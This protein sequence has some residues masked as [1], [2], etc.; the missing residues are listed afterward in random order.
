MNKIKIT[1]KELKE[2]NTI[3]SVGY[4]AMQSLLSYYYPI[5]YNSGIY[6]WNYDVYNIDGI[7]ICTGYRPIASQNIVPNYEMIRH[8]EKKAQNKTQKEKEKLLKQLIEK[9]QNK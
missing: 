6:G 7:I 3:L 4:C 9:L 2:N 1:N 8:Y 5:A